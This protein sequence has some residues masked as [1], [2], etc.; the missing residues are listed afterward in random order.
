MTKLM[1][2]RAQKK[3]SFGLEVRKTRR[4]GLVS[5]SSRTVR[6]PGWPGC[7][8]TGRSLPRSGC[9]LCPSCCRMSLA[10]SIS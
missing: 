4:G 8:A 6:L 10:R 7:T 2:L 5:S 1:E 3:S 9:K